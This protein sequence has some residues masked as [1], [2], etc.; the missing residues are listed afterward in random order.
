MK[1]LILGAFV[2][3][4]CVVLPS[5]AWAKDDG[6]N[7]CSSEKD[8]RHADGPAL[9][10]DG[11]SAGHGDEHEGS[12][13]GFDYKALSQDRENEWKYE[14]TDSNGS[15]HQPYNGFQPSGSAVPEPSGVILFM[16]GITGYAGQF[17]LK[18][19]RN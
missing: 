16:T 15:P 9:S 13:G 8:S 19:K 14:D 7:W 18:K 3:F 5:G 4:A 1:K 17:I 6:S 11:K 2:I 10:D 12:D